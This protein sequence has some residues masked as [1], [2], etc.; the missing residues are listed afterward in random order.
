VVGP[1]G[2]VSKIF[3]GHFLG[4]LSISSESSAQT[5]SISTLLD[6]TREKGGSVDVSTSQRGTRLGCRPRGEA[7][8]RSS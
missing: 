7:S 2:G 6:Q 8:Q 4:V 1:P 5:Q 3:L